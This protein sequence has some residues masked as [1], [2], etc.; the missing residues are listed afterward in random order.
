[1]MVSVVCGSKEISNPQPKVTMISNKSQITVVSM[2]LGSIS[3][4]S[5]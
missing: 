5:L 2:Y 4:V 3:W 1:M